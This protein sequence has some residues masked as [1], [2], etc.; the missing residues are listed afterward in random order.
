[1]CLVRGGR[2]CLVAA[3]PPARPRRDRPA[4]RGTRETRTRG[5]RGTGLSDCS[6]GTRRGRLRVAAIFTVAGRGR[7][8][9][10]GSGRAAGEQR[11]V[12][13]SSRAVSSSSSR[14]TDP[15]VTRLTSVF[16]LALS[17]YIPLLANASNHGCMVRCSN[18]PY[19]GTGR[20]TRRPHIHRPPIRR[21]G[22]EGDYGAA[23]LRR[24]VPF[25]NKALTR[26]LDPHPVL[27]L[28]YNVGEPHLPHVVWYSAA[29]I[30][31][32]ET[33]VEQV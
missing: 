8:A 27:R 2:W 5:G 4:G 11:S 6:R 12:S 15:R 24:G 26:S 33:V 3:F 20:R 22:E 25:S 14:S 30:G 29:G 31:R 1:M 18:R 13:S 19:G 17:A 28:A 10:E 7:I 32:R 16:R 9:L 21:Y 23:G